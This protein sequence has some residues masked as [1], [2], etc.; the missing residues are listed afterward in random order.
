MSLSANTTTI[1]PDTVAHEVY[2]AIGEIACSLR[3]DVVCALKEAKCNMG[4]YDSK[5]DL[6]SDEGA[7]AS[8]RDS[9]VLDM[10][11]ENDMIA[12]RDHVPICQDTGS[13]WVCLEVG[14][15]VALTGDIFSKVDAAVSDAY[16]ENALRMS[17]VKDA[18]FDRT[19]TQNNT[20]AF[21]EIKFRDKPGATLHVLLKGGGSD[22]ASR[23]IMCNPSDGKAGI[24]HHVLESVKQKAANAC[25]PLVLGIGIG[26]TFDKVAS[27]AKSALLRPVGSV[28]PD[29]S[30]AEF[31]Q[32]LL[33]AANETLIGPGAL[34]GYPTAV[35]VHIQSAPCHIAAL[36]LAI[37]MGCSAMRSKSIDI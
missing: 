18:L 1:T 16:T 7:L 20:P 23:L 5:G 34:G 9:D 10:I 11:L 27:L 8:N 2:Q 22:N 28:N 21:C 24:K 3:E 13:V 36:P 29:P 37:N 15:D 4:S 33:E 17:I 30:A 26:S 31:E 35:A 19:N 32:E 25:P 12:R 6:K 14:P